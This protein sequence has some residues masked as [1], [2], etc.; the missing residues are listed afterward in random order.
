MCQCHVQGCVEGEGFL[1]SQPWQFASWDE[2][3]ARL[4]PDVK[5]IHRLV[6]FSEGN[7]PNKAGFPWC[8][9][10]FSLQDKVQQCGKNAERGPPVQDGEK[11]KIENDSL[12]KECD[13]LRKVTGR[14]NWESHVFSFH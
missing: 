8:S 11:Q 12:K 5:I 2:K 7:T 3:R 4:T 10:N 13:C 14:A 9:A 1:P 6:L